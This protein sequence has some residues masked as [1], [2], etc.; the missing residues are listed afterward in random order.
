[1]TLQI[2]ALELHVDCETK[3]KKQRCKPKVGQKLADEVFIHHVG[4][5]VGSQACSIAC[6]VDLAW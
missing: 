1:M 4:E 3:K 5:K 2:K 6:N